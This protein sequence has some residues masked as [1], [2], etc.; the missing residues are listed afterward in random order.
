VLGV[1]GLILAYPI[2]ASGLMPGWGI[3]VAFWIHRIEA[4]LA[5]AHIFIIHFFVAHVRPAVFPMDRTIFEGSADLEEARHERPAWLERLEM[6]GKLQGCLVAE[7]PI[8]RRILFYAIGYL[9]VA[10]GLF[11]LIGGLVNVSYI[12]W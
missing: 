11:L 3:N 2:A 7:A 12:T 5:M 4:I 9:A 8:G 6:E 1:T 10:V